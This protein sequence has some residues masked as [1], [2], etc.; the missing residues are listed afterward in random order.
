MKHLIYKWLNKKYQQSY[1]LKKP[2]IGALVIF[3]FCFGFLSIYKPLGTHGEQNLSYK[4]TMAIYC[5]SFAISVFLLIIILKR[6]SYFSN[7]KDWTLLKELLFIAL[8][9]FSMGITVYFIA[10]FVEPP[11]PRWNFPTFIDSFQ[12]AFLIGIIP[13]LIFTI[14]NYRS[15]GTQTISPIVTST[16]KST[17]FAEKS[18]EIISKLKKERL[19]FNPSELLY[20]TSDGNYVVFYLNR[21]N[22]IEKEIIRNSMSNVEQQLCPIPFLMRT[23][24]AFIVNVKEVRIQKGNTL[25]YRLKLFGIDAEIPVSRSYTQPFN[26]LLSQYH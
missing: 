6:I 15:F 26:Q 18:I 13:F 12:N 11:A 8:S 10:F 25:G 9:M 14:I 7:S 17:E 3:V 23:H 1:I 20:A 5:L 22:K 2:Y 24:R 4:E 21:N 19:S 16:I